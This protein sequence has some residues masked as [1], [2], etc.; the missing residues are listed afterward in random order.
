MP[1][2]QRHALQHALLLCTEAVAVIWLTR[3]HAQR[4]QWVTMGRYRGVGMPRPK[5][6]QPAVIENLRAAAAEVEQA[7]EAAS[8][9]SRA[10]ERPPTAVDMQP[11][12]AQ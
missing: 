8:S 7:A 3:F 4:A 12:P 9:S 1:R 10:P 2:D 6:K 11:V 5:K